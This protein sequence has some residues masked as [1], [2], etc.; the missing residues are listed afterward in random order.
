MQLQMLCVGRD[1]CDYVVW[2]E[3]KHLIE[4]YSRNSTQDEIV[5]KSEKYFYNAS[6][7]E[8]LGKYHTQAKRRLATQ[9]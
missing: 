7:P 4:R 9:C 2:A 6:L 1:A 8:L 5:K 3:K